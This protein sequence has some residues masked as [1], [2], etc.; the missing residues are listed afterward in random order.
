MIAERLQRLLDDA[1]AAGD[2][3]GVAAAVTDG[4]GARFEGVAGVQALGGAAKITERT[5][6]WLASMS[7]PVTSLAALQLVEAGKLSLDAPVG[8]VLPALAAPMILQGGKLRP[9]EQKITLRHLL[10]HTA[11]FAYGFTNA[12]YAAYIAENNLPTGPGR[13]ASLDLPLLFEPGER[14]EYGI[15]TDWLGLVVEAASG[16]TLE[17]YLQNHVFAPLG[18]EDSGFLPSEAQRARLA[19]IHQRQSDGA[20]LADPPQP[21]RI[22]EFFS[23]GGGLYSTLAD[24]QKF[25]RVFLTGGAG[26]LSAQGIAEMSRHQIGAL[27]P[28]AI[29]SATPGLIANGDM[30]PGQPSEWGLGFL[31]FPQKGPFGRNPGSFGWAGMANTYFWVD[32]AAGLAVVILMQVL[33]LGDMRAAKTYT[34]FERAVYA[35]AN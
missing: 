17:A 15:S 9:A 12:E 23:G 26:I 24:Y 30:N 16:E 31:I 6:F 3:A 5:L 29:P 32:P 1:V 7:K 22:P 13:R 19:A 35:V 18:M 10:T 28:G 33:P 14:W 4:R 34:R 21:P 20:L 8:E 27:R 25:L 11:G 2:V